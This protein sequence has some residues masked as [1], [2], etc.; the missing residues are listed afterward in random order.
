MYK[1][2]F[3]FF[4]AWV[5]PLSVYAIDTL[6]NN[7]D[8]GQISSA[9][10]PYP[11][12]TIQTISDGDMR[13]M[14]RDNDTTVSGDYFIGHYYDSIYGVFEVWNSIW[15][16]LQV[17]TSPAT[18]DCPAATHDGYKL[19]WYS[20]NPLFWFVDFNWDPSTYAYICI[21]RD[22]W[23]PSLSSYLGWYAYSPLIW[24]Q[25]FANINIDS[26]VDTLW[27][28]E[29]DG[30]LVRVDGNTSSQN[31]N[32]A[33]ADQF[34][35]DIRILWKLT[36]STFRRDIQQNIFTFIRNITPPTSWSLNVSSLS[37]SE[38]SLWSMRAST[39]KNNEILY[40]SPNGAN[41]TLP[42]ENNLSW[43]KTLVVEWGNIYITWNITGSW[44]LWLIAIEKDNQWWN[45]Y[46]DPS[47]TDIHAIMYADKSLISYNGS[48]LDGS[49]PSSVLA[50]QLYIYGSIFSENTIWGSVTDTC[51]FY[52]NSTCTP[53]V[54]RK[55]D[56]NYIRRYVRV[57]PTD[58]SGASVWPTIP[59][60]WWLESYMWDGSNTNT[61][62]QK[63]WYEVYPLIIEYNPGVQVTPPPL[64]N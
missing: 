3:L 23:D 59:Q 60:Y 48:E 5:I 46:I 53:A 20:Y 13:F 63:P 21:L 41:V 28:H 42:A 36:K 32:E 26:V 25:W 12:Q 22:Y 31:N 64:F 9:S 37:A 11:S 4:F 27:D 54:S 17:S 1:I 39:I 2:L 30:R 10:W 7:I 52:E 40:F 55:Y 6:I 38:W 16:W 44:I 62:T 45:I 29:T 19:S 43:V 57:Q 34:D 15:P 18:W 49:T 47:V 8:G 14:N 58:A 33:I 35:D 24:L 61:Q 56:L 51:P 50:N